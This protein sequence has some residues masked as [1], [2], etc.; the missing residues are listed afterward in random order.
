M[1]GTGNGGRGSD[2]GGAGSV[3][4]TGS[5]G[6]GGIASGV[7]GPANG[8]EVAVNASRAATRVAQETIAGG[9]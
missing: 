6:G 9:G 4:S 2:S 3:G 8:T 7:C 5:G 1:G